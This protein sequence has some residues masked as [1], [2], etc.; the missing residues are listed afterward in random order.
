MAPNV[1]AASLRTDWR[2]PLCAVRLL[3]GKALI[4]DEIYRE[5][6]ELGAELLSIVSRWSDTLDG[7]AVLRLLRDYNAGR[8][9]LRSLR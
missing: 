4:A 9:T 3:R 8:P 5:L 2:P 6:E 1:T 7:P